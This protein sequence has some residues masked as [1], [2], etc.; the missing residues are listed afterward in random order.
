LELLSRYAL[1]P[2]FQEDVNEWVRGS[3]WEQEWKQKYYDA[4]LTEAEEKED[5]KKDKKKTHERPDDFKTVHGIF[6]EH[7]TKVPLTTIFI[8]PLLS[9]FL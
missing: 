3:Q 6:V 8:A 2:E 5:G 1:E 4:P 7:I 9:F